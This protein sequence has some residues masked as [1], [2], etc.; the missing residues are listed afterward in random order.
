MT[1]LPLLLWEQPVRKSEQAPS[2]DQVVQ[3]EQKHIK[4]PGRTE[5]PTVDEAYLRGWMI[6]FHK[7]NE[8][9]VPKGIR[10]WNY[11]QLQQEYRSILQ[12]HGIT[13]KDIVY[14]LSY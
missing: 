14:R 4:I 1:Q 8:L 9:P 2:L 13:E 3:Q 11:N 6:E 5:L 7:K 12:K 10:D